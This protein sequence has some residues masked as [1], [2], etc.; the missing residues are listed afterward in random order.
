[1]VGHHAAEQPHG[2]PTAC[3][4]Q[5]TRAKTSERPMQ[6]SLGSRDLLPGRGTARLPF[7][8]LASILL[9]S[10]DRHVEVL[11]ARHDFGQIAG[12]QDNG[13][14]EGRVWGSHQDRCLEP[15]CHLTSHPYLQEA[16]QEEHQAAEQIYGTVGNRAGKKDGK[17]VGGSTAKEESA[18]WKV[19]GP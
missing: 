11:S 1:M 12:Q 14:K 9:T 10:N 18:S 4:K 16:Q 17:G 6:Q 5:V 19:R 2:P 8:R 15:G 13:V 3:P 7:S